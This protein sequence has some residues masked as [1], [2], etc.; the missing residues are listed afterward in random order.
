VIP[1]SSIR[2][3]AEAAWVQGPR[4]EI[5][6]P[7]VG[8]AVLLDLGGGPGVYARALVER[9]AARVCWVDASATLESIAREKLADLSGVE[10]RLADM[11]DLSA[12]PDQSFDGVLFRD[13]L[14]HALDE[15]RVLREVARVLK[16]GGWLYLE[17]PTVGRVFAERT[18]ARAVVDMLLAALGLLLGRKPRAT[19]FCSRRAV[20]ARL[21]QAGFEVR[22]RDGDRRRATWLARRGR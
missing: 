14:H 7:D 16:P 17:F 8:G 18:P 19:W 20:Q 4:F 15:A 3:F 5:P 22:Q 1:E 13:A 10:F 6:L 9:G 2:A 21:S 12:Y 11:G